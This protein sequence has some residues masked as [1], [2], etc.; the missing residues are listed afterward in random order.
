VTGGINGNAA[1][2]SAELFDS[3]NGSF[4]PAGNMETERYEHRATSLANGEVLITG[5]INFDNAAGLNSLASAEL[6]Q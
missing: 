1:L 2:S 4:T 5:G 6:F 3:A